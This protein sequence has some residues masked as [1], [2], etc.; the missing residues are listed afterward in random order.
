MAVSQ[1]ICAPSKRQAVSA[2][3]V[4]FHSDSRGNHWHQVT[5]FRGRFESVAVCM[6]NQ[7]SL[8]YRMADRLADLCRIPNDERF[9]MYVGEL[10]TAR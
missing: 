8:A 2:F 6:V 4:E 9:G 7:V 1:S 5:I 3:L 10:Q